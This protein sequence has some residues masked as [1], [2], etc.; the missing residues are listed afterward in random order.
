MNP[1]RIELAIQDVQRTLRIA[2]VHAVVL[3]GSAARGEATEDSDIDLLIILRPGQVVRRAL[4]AIEQVEKER[5]VRISTLISRSAALTDIDRQLLESI[6]RQGKP[7][8]GALPPLGMRELDLEPVR[9]LTL[10]LK[11]LSQISKVRLERELFGYRSRHRYRGKV[12]ASRTR[13]RLELLGGRRVGRLVI[14]PEA[15]VGEVERVLRQHGARRVLVP[16]WIQRP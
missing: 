15:A 14:V 9:L 1:S 10:N 6:V 11:G 5:K 12:Y 13:G 4:G 3:F 7:L 2:G 16:A 8:V